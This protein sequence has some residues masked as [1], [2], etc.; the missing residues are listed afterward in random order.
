M[1]PHKFTIEAVKCA[2]LMPFALYLQHNT[3]I[4][5]V[6]AVFNGCTP[7]IEREIDVGFFWI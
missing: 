7:H 2:A 5:T 1:K 3:L 6:I 4:F